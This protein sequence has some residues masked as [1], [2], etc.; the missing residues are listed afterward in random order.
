M[1]PEKQILVGVI[2]A[3][4]FA[5]GF[6]VYWLLGRLEEKNVEAKGKPFFAA[7]VQAHAG[8]YSAGTTDSAAQV[9]ICF[10]GVPNLEVYL[11]QLA[12]R[13]LKLSRTIRVG[14]DKVSDVDAALAVMD[15]RYQPRK[16]TLLPSEFTG[17]HAV[18]C[19]YVMLRRKHLPAGRLSKPWIACKA[20]P[21]SRGRLVMTSD[22]ELQSQ[23]THGNA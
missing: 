13:A 2:V 21:G 6:A 16:R 12:A 20:F 7:I 23:G 14:K 8:M 9:L 3:A 5:T 11:Q 15:T 17:G 1:P 19:A 10:E 4:V 18:Y 22:S